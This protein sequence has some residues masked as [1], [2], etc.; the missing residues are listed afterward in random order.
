MF[1]AS[2]PSSPQLNQRPVR[3]G[4]VTR[5]A[6]ARASAA[7]APRPSAANV[8]RAPIRGQRGRLE[9]LDQA[10]DTVRD[11]GALLYGRLAAVIALVLLLLVRVDRSWD[12]GQHGVLVR[13]A[14]DL[15]VM[16]RSRDRLRLRWR[17]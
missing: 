17:S 12:V 14:D 4:Q 1:T 6:S 5:R 13:Y 7:D 9:L 10:A 3:D 8:F 2:R 16:C 15:V 11:L